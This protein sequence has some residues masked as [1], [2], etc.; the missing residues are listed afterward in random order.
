M[1]TTNNTQ[2]T[3]EATIDEAEA[4]EIESQ[5]DSDSFQST[6]SGSDGEDGHFSSHSPPLALIPSAKERNCLPNMMDLSLVH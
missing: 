6:D 1:M 5:S 3:V 4:Q 2:N